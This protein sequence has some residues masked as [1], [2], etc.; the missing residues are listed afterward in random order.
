MFAILLGQWMGRRKRAANEDGAMANSIYNTPPSS[1]EPPDR[2][3]LSLTNSF[4]SGDFFD[5]KT[6]SIEEVDG[7]ELKSVEDVDSDKLDLVAELGNDNLK[8]IDKVGNGNLASV[9]GLGTD[10]LSPIGDLATDNLK[11]IKEHATGNPS[12]IED[13]DTDDL[14]SITDLSTDNLAS[15]EDLSTANLKPI[16]GLT[17]DNLTS[18]TDLSIDNL[19]SAHD[20]P[21]DNLATVEEVATHELTSIEDLTSDNLPSIKDELPSDSSLLPCTLHTPDPTLSLDSNE[22]LDRSCSITSEFLKT[23]DLSLSAIEMA[24]T[25]QLSVTA[26]I[27]DILHPFDSF[28]EANP[29]GR[30]VSNPFGDFQNEH[31]VFEVLNSICERVAQVEESGQVDEANKEANGESNVEANSEANRDAL[32]EANIEANMNGSRR[33]PSSLESD[34]TDISESD[35]SE[36]VSD[37]EDSSELAKKQQKKRHSIGGAADRSASPVRQLEHEVDRLD[38]DGNYIPEDDLNSDQD[39]LSS[40]DEQQSSVGRESSLVCEEQEFPEEPTNEE[41]AEEQEDPHDYCKGGYYPVQIGQVFNGR[42]HVI[43]KVGWGHFSTVW[44]CWDVK[45]CRFVALKIVKSAENYAVSAADEIT[46]LR[47]CMDK[48]PHHGKSRVIEF[49][50]SFKITGVNGDHTCMV[51]EVL[52]CTLLKLIIGTNYSGLMLEHVRVIIK[53]VLEGLSYLHDDCNII[54]TDLKPENVLVEMTDSEIRKMASDTIV[55]LNLG[56]KP[57]IT[58]ACNM[59]KPVEKKMSKNA[60]KKLK[61][62][63]KKQ[64]EKQQNEDECPN[65]SNNDECEELDASPSEVI[66][67]SAI[68]DDLMNDDHLPIHTTGDWSD[69]KNVENA[70]EK[71]TKKKKKNKRSGKDKEHEIESNEQKRN[72]KHHHALSHL[73]ENCSF[74]FTKSEEPTEEFGDLPPLKVKIADL[75]NACWTTQHFTS[76]IQTRQ[77]RAL[78]VIIGAGYDTSADIWS[79]ACIAFELATGDYL[80][81]PHGGETYGR[82]ED[83][84]AHMIELLGIIPPSIFKR[85]KYWQQYFNKFGGLLHIPHLR[86]WSLYE[87]LVEKYQ[88]P[89]R[90]A[91]GFAD[92]LLPMLEF[93]PAK[94]IRATDALKRPWINTP[95]SDDAS[96]YSPQD[97]GFSSRKYS[98]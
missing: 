30:T 87:V 57:D 2:A 42:Y 11:P 66:E 76:E 21:T 88:W 94:R 38:D 89:E 98:I 27:K 46:I 6:V 44:L 70:N 96:S 23:E 75:G 91:Q 78:E 51:F 31:T 29:D 68:S 4:S 9:K 20:L 39:E 34:M 40:L 50:D 15:V 35:T 5:A 83:H 86:P 43:R 85:G 56:L 22:L 64:L 93:D 65:T 92:F 25:L 16:E 95:I 73:I 53:Q 81:E 52:G 72:G 54:H 67:S 47:E 24:P 80:F 26:L 33:A 10:N 17:H 77:Y 69:N 59:A 97:N 58:E 45:S 3:K 82:D 55:K 49:L 41:N 12:P 14:T 90:Q 63:K 61:K 60:K 84:L 36:T 48:G 8:P 37:S 13:L 71:T 28:L 62:R 32:T 7:R 18:V 74:D 19:T 1:P 79:V